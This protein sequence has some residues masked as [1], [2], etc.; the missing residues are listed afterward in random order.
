MIDVFVC[1]FNRSEYVT[2]CEDYIE[3]DLPVG[4]G[5]LEN[6]KYKLTKQSKNDFSGG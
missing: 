1:Q 5:K 2:I 4:K 3:Y 6:P